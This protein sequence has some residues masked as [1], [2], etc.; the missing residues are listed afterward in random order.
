M[1]NNPSIQS[2][3]NKLNGT[4]FR[5][6]FGFG[7]YSS[8]NPAY[9]YYVMD[10]SASKVSILNDNWSFISVKTFTNPSYFISIANSLY[11]TGQKNVWEV[12]QDLNILIDYNPSGS[13]PGY[14]GI[15]YNPSNGLLYVVA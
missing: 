4:V 13:T 14:R 7:M 3:F 6:L 5:G 9:Y 2:N 11:M 1:F 8:S 12:D 10:H 15:S